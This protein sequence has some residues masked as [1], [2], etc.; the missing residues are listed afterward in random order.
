MQTPLLPIGFGL[1]ELSDAQVAQ[2]IPA[3][4]QAGFR[5]FDTAQLYR[6]EAALGRAIKVIGMP[7]DQ[8]FVTTK[9]MNRNFSED[10]FLPSV[11]ESLDRLQLDCVDLLLVH[12]PG[13][14]MSIERQTDLLNEAHDL[15]L[16]R[17][18]GVSNYNATQLESAAQITRALSGGL[19]EQGARLRRDPCGVRVRQW[20]EA[21]RRE[22]HRR[23]YQGSRRG[24]W[25]LGG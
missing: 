24:T 13:Y 10:R 5:A 17:H 23:G 9:V 6:N 11:R 12:W 7:R 18:I 19:L 4:W 3:A 25:P 20:T 15:G 2:L 16:T 1:D 8:V 21:R 22:E 14:A